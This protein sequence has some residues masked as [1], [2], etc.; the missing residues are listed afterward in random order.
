MSERNHHRTE[1]NGLAD[2]FNKQIREPF[3][4]EMENGCF[5]RI[6]NASVV[7]HNAMVWQLSHQNS[8]EI[9]FCLKDDEEFPGTDNIEQWELVFFPMYTKNGE[10]VSHGSIVPYEDSI[11]NGNIVVENKVVT[12]FSSNHIDPDY[13][14]LQDEITIFAKD[15][16]EIVLRGC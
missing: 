1:V 4:I 15:F 8:V 13:R 14:E 12:S 9:K 6:D 11:V 16:L 7:F 10:E 5:F 2:C 3:V